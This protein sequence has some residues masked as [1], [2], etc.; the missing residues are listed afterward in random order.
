MG[1]DWNYTKPAPLAWRKDFNEREQTFVADTAYGEYR[2]TRRVRQDKWL[3]AMPNA[4][5]ETVGSSHEGRRV[6]E[7]DHAERARA[8]EIVRD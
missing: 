7:I 4:V 2:V 1:T 6:A 8:V 5:P 3:V